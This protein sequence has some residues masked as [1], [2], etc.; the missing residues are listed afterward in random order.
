MP[1]A[2]NRMLPGCLNCWTDVPGYQGM[3]VQPINYKHTFC[4]TLKVSL[5]FCRICHRNQVNMVTC[6]SLL[7]FKALSKIFET[8]E[9]A[10]VGYVNIC[11]PVC[12]I[13]G[14]TEK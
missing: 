1:Q 7:T 11:S 4:N 5:V 9:G 13:F 3:A 6:P 10:T 2:E 12:Q 14:C 8:Q